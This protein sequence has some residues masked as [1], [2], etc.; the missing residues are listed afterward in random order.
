MKI[1]RLKTGRLRNE[2]WFRFHTEFVG[3]ILLYGAEL[4]GLLRFFIPYQGLY[5]EAD[6]L[7][8]VLLKSFITRDTTETNEKRCKVFKGL[9]D[10]AKSFQNVLDPEKQ[11]A[12][13]KVYAVANKYNNDIMK[14][15]LAAK[16]GAIDNFLQDLKGNQGSGLDLTREVELLGL[17]VWVND[18]L[19]VNEEYKQLH[20]E[21]SDET[22]ERPDPGRLKE[23]RREVDH[24]YV[25]MINVVDA[26]LQAGNDGKGDH[27]ETPG[28]D[29]D[30][31]PSGPVEDRNEL[32]TD[33]DQ[34]LLHFAKALNARIANYK[35]LLKG[36]QTR[37]DNKDAE[38]EP[39]EEL[40]DEE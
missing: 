22:A 8:E 25:N 24:R 17:N 1:T 18:L 36:R 6:H 13:I 33:P 2:E 21:R 39:E 19:T 38:E 11:N 29:E 7:L 27:E 32:P 26:L 23:V 12:A 16:T 28:E 30:E 31:E 34:R 10:T 15:S 5:K 9:R 14:G 35:A 37:S 20:S 3:L 40:P 4:L